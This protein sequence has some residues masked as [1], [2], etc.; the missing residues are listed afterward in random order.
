MKYRSHGMRLLF[1]LFVSLA[2]GCGSAPS[3]P[4]E[5]TL[6]GAGA[7]FPAPVYEAWTTAFSELPNGVTVTYERANS[8]EGIRRVTAGEV[9]FGGTDRPLD[10]AE[11][12]ERGLVQIPMVLGGVAIVANLPALGD[13]KLQLSGEVLARIFLGEIPAW[14]HPDIAALN[15]EA[16]LP[17]LPIQPIHRADA[18]GQKYIITD[19]LAEVSTLFREKVGIGTD[20]VFPA[21][22][23]LQGKQAVVDTLQSTVGA[24]GYVEA[25]RALS[26]GLQQAA[27]QNRE[28]AFVL[29]TIASLAAAA[30]QEDWSRPD[31]GQRLLGM[32]GAESYPLTSATFLLLPAE[33]ESPQRG[34]A[35]R[36]FL[37]WCLDK[38]ETPEGMTYVALPRG[39]RDTMKS[40]LER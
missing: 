30:N 31:A 34:E 13:A 15:P 37:A 35:L 2:A 14:D 28:G 11:L 3:P 39:A 40:R 22:K 5:I 29:P 25:N 4:R 17:A 9:D 7:N 24:L 36:A 27:V 26:E 6:R 38:P 16:T 21:G 32:P 23:A 1:V 19:Y 8:G 33:A 18:S 20:A 12:Q 10:A